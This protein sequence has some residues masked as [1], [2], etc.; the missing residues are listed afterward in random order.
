[1]DQS[2]NPSI[3]QSID[4][5]KQTISKPFNLAINEVINPQINQETNCDQSCSQ[6]LE[7][8]F[9]E[10]EDIEEASLD[11]LKPAGYNSEESLTRSSALEMLT[12]HGKRTLWSE[13]PEVRI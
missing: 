6:H 9:S 4:Q 7:S 12:L 8:K 11:N 2:I 13:I 1:L 5:I 3:N 10:T